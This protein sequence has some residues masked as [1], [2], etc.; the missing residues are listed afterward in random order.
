MDITGVGCFKN[1]E[2]SNQATVVLFCLI[3]RRKCQLFHLRHCKVPASVRQQLPKDLK[4]RNGLDC[5]W[6][7]QI[8]DKAHFRHKGMIRLQPSMCRF[9]RMSV[10]CKKTQLVALHLKQ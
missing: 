7:K 8:G 6:K 9:H 2:C 10:K 1:G 3:L 4:P 5:A